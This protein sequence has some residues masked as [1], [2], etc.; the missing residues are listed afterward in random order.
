[1][2]TIIN[3]P[4]NQGS[5]EGSGLSII[6]GILSV[7]LIAFL[8]YIYG[9]PMLRGTDEKQS[10]VQKIEIQLPATTPTPKLTE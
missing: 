6:I 5:D 9:I 1:M 7:A 8:F 2:T 10:A 4:A 3:N